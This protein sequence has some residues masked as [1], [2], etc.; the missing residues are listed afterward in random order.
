VR[1][2]RDNSEVQI[3]ENCRNIF[4]TDLTRY[5]TREMARA[6]K[7]KYAAKKYVRSHGGN[8]SGYTACHDL[9]FSQKRIS[10]ILSIQRKI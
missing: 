9:F 2:P 6:A 7:F 3:K 4:H 5:R 1:F 10:T 8:K